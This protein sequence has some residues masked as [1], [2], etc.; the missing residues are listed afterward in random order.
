MK[1]FGLWTRVGGLVVGV[2]LL[3]GCGG[4]KQAERPLVFYPPPPDPPRL[5]Y[6]LTINDAKDWQAKPSSSFADFIVGSAKTAESPTELKSPYG[7]AMR[8]GKIYVCDLGNLRIHVIDMANKRYATLGT[9]DQV[10]KPANITID[11]DGTKY[12]S[13]AGKQMVMV[14]DAQDRFVRAMGDPARCAGPISVAIWK[15][16]LYVAD[17]LGGKIEVWTKDG[18]LKRTISSKG[19]GPPQL[20]RPSSLVFNPQGHLFVTDMEL[21][22]IKEFDAEGK[23]VKSI[24]MPGDR[25]GY[26]ARPKG[27]A[28]DPAGRL[29]VADAQWDKI[30]IFTPEGQLLLFFGESSPL[31]H[32][33]VTPTGVAID[34]T[35][36]E[37]L[38]QYVDKSFEPEYL[39]LVTNQFGANRL[40]IH[41]F[42][43]AKPPEAA[44]PAAET[45]AKSPTKD[46]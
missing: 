44:A 11:A 33:M 43:H 22:V 28:I 32:G 7:V 42:G 36:V 15:D 35:S 25:P 6:L 9:A 2:V 27:L 45:A 38:R 39:V 26:F 1:S 14:F 3:A 5:Q 31:P 8:D 41:A 40:V 10:T 20:S 34:T 19:K 30:Q 29:Y 16:E 24:G 4:G 17:A 21:A 18:Q 12:V 46:G 13:D 23:Y 37:A